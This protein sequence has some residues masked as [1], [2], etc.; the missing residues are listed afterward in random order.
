[1]RAPRLAIAAAL[2]AITTLAGA[3]TT[4]TVSASIPADRPFAVENL[5]GTMTIVPGSGAEVRVTA[6]VHGETAALAESLR[7]EE[8]RGENGRRTLRLTYPVD[9]HRR[10][11]YPDAGSSEVRYDGR[12]VRV[13]S[14][15]GVSLWAAVT[16]EVPRG[17]VTADFRNMVGAI[18]A[19]GIAGTILLDSSSGEINARDLAGSIKADTGSGTVRGSGLKGTFTCDTGSGACLVEGFDGD[20]LTCD[21]GSGR[22]RVRQASA[23]VLVADTG[24][25]S[26]E[27]TGADVEEFRGDTGSGSITFEAEGARLRRVVADTGS[28]GVTIRLP[29]ET[30]FELRADVGSG[31]VRSRFEDAEPITSGRKVVGFRRGDRMVSIEA[32]T[33]SGSVTV[34]PLR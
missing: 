17:E 33:G 8:V 22:I 9:R 30:G 28:G 21:T 11:R 32:D 14:R 3:E 31:G 2:L 20:R 6:I 5:A 29:R 27:V 4:R 12:R 1:M 19:E 15:S 7:I 25:G 23:R 13:S 18:D 10:F 34:A 26:V 24:S 16:V